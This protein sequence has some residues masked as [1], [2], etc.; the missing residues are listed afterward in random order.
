MVV[1]ASRTFRGVEIARTG[2]FEASTGPVTF[3]TQDFDNAEKAYKAIGEKQP[4]P[5]KLGHDD[6]QSLVQED[7]YPNAGFLR[8]IK[9]DGD[10]LVADLVDVPDPVGILIEQ[11]RLNARSIEALRNAQMDGKKWPFVI[12]GL[13][14]L[15]A[16]LP[17]VDSLKDVVALY[18]SRG[19]K[20][21]EVEDEAELVMV[22]ASTSEEGGYVDVDA[23]IEELNKLLGRT[24]A[25]IRYRGGAPKFRTLVRTAVDEL[26]SIAKKKAKAK[27]E[28]DMDVQVVAKALGLPETATEEEVTAKITENNAYVDRFNKRLK[29]DMAAC[30]AD[31]GKWDSQAMTCN[32]AS[33]SKDPDEVT[34]LKAQLADTQKEVV[35]LKD[36][37]AKSEAT[38]KVDTAIRARKFTPAARDTLIKLAISSP[39]QF[40]EMVKATPDNA[41][42]AK[43]GEAGHDGET[44]G[45]TDF[46]PSAEQAK[47]LAATGVSREEF[48]EQRARDLGKPVPTTVAKVLA[49]RRSA[50]K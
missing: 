17:A 5:I 23:L 19:I 1:L 21:P 40:D 33:A 14:L 10:R 46:E 34:K 50:K 18:A 38:T 37:D 2:K 29:A 15:G 30:E 12:T 42:L 11:G 9:R 24:E 48:I 6:Q 13:A 47:I 25:V 39:T 26:R 7:G 3:T 45:T 43:A 22:L 41:I 44:D 31:G 8:N 32:K 4:S 16:D 28:K 49:E 27:K 35:T 36:K 20:V